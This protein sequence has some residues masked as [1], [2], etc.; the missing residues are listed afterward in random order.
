[1]QE[2]AV[3]IGSYTCFAFFHFIYDWKFPGFQPD[4]SSYDYDAPLSENGDYTDKY[5]AVQRLTAEYNDLYIRQPS[6]PNATFRTVYPEVDIIGELSLDDLMQQSE[7]HIQSETI[8]P[9]EKLDINDGNGQSYGYVVYRKENLDIAPG[10]VLKIEGHVCDTVLVLINGN[11]V[12]KVLESEEDLNGFGYWRL[13]DSTICL[14]SETSYTSATLDL[15]VENFGR[16][17]YGK[18]LEQFNQFKGLWQGN[19]LLNGTVINDWT[20]VPLEF[21]KKWTLGLKNWR[22]PTFS[23]G[24]HLYK[25]ILDIKDVD[26]L[27]DTYLDFKGWTK[28]FMIVNG[29][30]LTRFFKVGP[31]QAGYLPAPF[32]KVGENEI[33]VFE[34]FTPCKSVNFCPDPY[35]ETLGDG[36]ILRKLLEWYV[37]CN[38]FSFDLQC[39]VFIS[40]F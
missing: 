14:G 16:V 38:N 37:L 25:A 9:M 33:V 32:L 17:N 26:S 30:V 40:I 5:L 27:K 18:K 8:L 29:F 1:M 24:P 28:G 13:K 15:V 2:L 22:Q 11:L 23:T 4:T 3:F 19:V 7:H 21:K 6:P 20:I 39:S 10:S 12:N 36:K 35:F 31:Q 34:H